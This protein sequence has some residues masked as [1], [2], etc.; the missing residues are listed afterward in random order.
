MSEMNVMR[1][2]NRTIRHLRD[3]SGA[4]T[5]ITAILMT[6][7][8]GMAA[9]VIDIGA[10]EARRAQLQD[11]ADAAAVGIARA[12]PPAMGVS[13]ERRPPPHPDTPSTTSTT[14]PRRWAR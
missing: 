1:A 3:E 2:I 13:S 6:V 9:L 8:L 12:W 14:T 5:V 4:I 11:A 10:A 7:M